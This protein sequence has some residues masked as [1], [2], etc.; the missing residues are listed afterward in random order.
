MCWLP[1]FSINNQ[2]EGENQRTERAH[3]R[4]PPPR[5]VPRDDPPIIERA[6]PTHLGPRTCG[7]CGTMQA[8]HRAEPSVARCASAEPESHAVRDI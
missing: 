6:L 5:A 7:R 8:S 3:T 1:R 2:K 4:A